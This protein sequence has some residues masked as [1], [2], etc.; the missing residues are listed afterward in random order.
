[1]TRDRRPSE[2]LR[3]VLLI[4]LALV[5]PALAWT[6]AGAQTA[7]TEADK[8]WPFLAGLP[9]EQRQAV[10]EREASREGGL[11]L[12]GALGIDRAEFL[13]KAFNGRYPGIKVSFV[14]LTTPDLTEKVLLEHRLGRVAVDAVISEPSQLLLLQDALAPYEPR[15]WT[16]FDPRFVYG[17]A[18]KGWTAVAYELLP[19]TIAWRTDRIATK[20]APKNLEELSDPKWKGRAGTTTHLESFIENMVTVHGEEKGMAKVR[21][22]AQLDNRLYRSHAALGEALAA[23]AVDIVWNLGAH[24]PVKMKE[25]GQPVDWAF[26]DP[27]FGTGVTISVTR[28]AKKP[29]AA[30][31]FMDFLLEADTLQKLEALEGGRLFGNREGKFKY[32]LAS[33]PTIILYPPVPK[34][35]FEEL[36]GI[37]ETLYFRKQ[38]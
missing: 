22:L 36:N 33:F 24:R 26:Q 9:K 17:G 18:A 1:M 29:Y 38:Y 34:K 7:P 23:G 25:A 14:R 3:R 11:V 4:A 15:S 2:A 10:L 27:L 30:A 35:R 16:Q 19:S 5:V 37:A 12:Y 6:P 32:S 28:G 21:R 20:D 8:A 13:T 31:L